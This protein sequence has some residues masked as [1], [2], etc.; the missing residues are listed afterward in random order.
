MKRIHFF[1]VILLLGSFALMSCGQKEEE[2]PMP[3]GFTL[4][5]APPPS[6]VMNPTGGPTDAQ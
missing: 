4:P 3:P 1:F 5:T 2:F 6:S